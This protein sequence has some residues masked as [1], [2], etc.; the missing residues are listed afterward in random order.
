[1]KKKNIALIAGIVAFGASGG[2]IFGQILNVGLLSVGS[3]LFAGLTTAAVFTGFGLLAV[4]AVL[5][6]IGCYQ[7]WKN[8]VKKPDA[9]NEPVSNKPIL[10]EFPSNSSKKYQLSRLSSDVLKHRVTEYLGETDLGAFAST[11]KEMLRFFNPVRMLT[12]LLRSVV[13]GN[14]DRV[15]EILQRYPHLAVTKGPVT[16]KPGRTFPMVSAAELVRW[17]GDLRYTFPCVFPCCTS[18]DRAAS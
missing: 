4:S 17:C 10:N 11:N 18:E 6:G 15:I 2:L 7:L 12:A 5:L 9:P 1:M 13:T 3:V 8:R 16:D 14:Q